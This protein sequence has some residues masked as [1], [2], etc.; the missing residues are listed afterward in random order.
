[1]AT[2]DIALAETLTALVE[3]TPGV[4]GLFVPSRVVAGGDAG[5]LVFAGLKVPVPAARVVIDR[6]RR[7]VSASIGIDA[8]ASAAST[9]EAVYTRM[10]EELV[11]ME[12]DMTISVTIAY[13]TS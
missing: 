12:Q 5:R 10:R 1:M 13:T 7:T 3:A 2:T 9:G 4:T 8:S 6:T 11:L